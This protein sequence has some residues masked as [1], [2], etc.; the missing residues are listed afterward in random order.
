MKAITQNPFRTLGVWSN[1]PAS[2]IATN[3]GRLS[4]FIRVGR[5]T[6]FPLDMAH[7][8]GDVDRTADTITAADSQLSMPADRLLAAQFWFL[9]LTPGDTL[10][11]QHLAA[12]RTDEA[13]ALWDG[14]DNISA[15]QN[16]AILHLA[17]GNTT[18][19]TQAVARLYS[20]HAEEFIDS[21]HL[22]QPATAED[23]VKGYTTTLMAES[24]DADLTPLLGSSL[25]DD[26]SK[27]AAAPLIAQL[28]SAIA[29]ACTLRKQDANQAFNA[30]KT[31][32]E[33]AKKIMERLDHLLAEDDPMLTDIA[34]RAALEILYC[35]TTTFEVDKVVCFMF[36][37]KLIETAEAIVKGPLAKQKIEKFSKWHKEQLAIVR[38]E[39][40]KRFQ[41]PSTFERGC[42][43][44]WIFGIFSFIIFFIIVLINSPATSRKKE[45]YKPVPTWTPPPITVPD[46]TPTPTINYED[47]IQ[48]QT[49]DA[50]VDEDVLQR[51]NGNSEPID[52]EMLDKGH[53][54]LE[55]INRNEHNQISEP[56]SGTPE[57]SN[58]LEPGG[59]PEPSNSPEPG[60]SPEPSNGA[61]PSAQQNE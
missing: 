24:P 15:L 1:A 3:K 5:K 55:Y 41:P 38:Q 23:L 22:N 11:A 56:N 53:Y 50:T 2:D 28:N 57:P 31:L 8:L 54:N 52:F 26:A 19:A 49:I 46:H 4:A 32:A 29:T 27:D 47:Y 17:L 51:I 14:R 60:G 9:N 18:A 33:T 40:E 36:G 35:M 61:G 44:A 25:G 6:D 7:I 13:L 10:A 12:G 39:A 34:D 37:T 59:S 16:S 20:Q 42:A 48:P 43:M 30:G 58:S 21:L 45:P